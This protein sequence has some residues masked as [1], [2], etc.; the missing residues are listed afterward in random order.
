MNNFN[1]LGVQ[2]MA[3][4]KVKSVNGRIS[5]I[6]FIATLAILATYAVGYVV[7]QAYYYLTC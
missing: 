5:T 3:E 7:G 2:Q 6:L 1:N 4:Q